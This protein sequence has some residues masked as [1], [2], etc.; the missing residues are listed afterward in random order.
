M[1]KY[2]EHVYRI[3]MYII[4]LLFILAILGVSS[5]IPKYLKYMRELVKLFVII[6]LIIR[7]NPFV[8]KVNCISNF[9]R[10]LIFSA[11]IFLL[12]STSLINYLE[13]IFN[14]L[15]DNKYKDIINKFNF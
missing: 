2:Y 3:V 8:K 6:F 1:K 7:F 11:S 4:Y 10:E 9:D 14:Y 13:Y 5:Y 15:S 12:L